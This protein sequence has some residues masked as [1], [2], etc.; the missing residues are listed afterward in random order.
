MSRNKS[1]NQTEV[2]TKIQELFSHKGFNG[3]SVDDLVQASGLSRSSLYDTFGDK[4]NLFAETFLLYRNAS[5]REMIHEIE[6]STD[7]K[8]TIAAIFESIYEDSLNKKKLGCMMVNTA[9]ELAPHQKKISKL[10]DDEMAMIQN[11]LTTAIHKAQSQ[12]KVSKKKSADALANLVITCINGLRVA[13]KWGAK[14]KIYKDVSQT[15][16]SLF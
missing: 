6:S 1:F 12:N 7:I 4:E 3:T 13:E 2:L 5:T 15:V 10:I 9:I 11:A 14:D 16:I 8:K